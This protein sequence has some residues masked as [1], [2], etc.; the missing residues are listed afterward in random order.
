MLR[1]DPPDLADD[2]G[3]VLAR[4]ARRNE[5]LGRQSVHMRAMIKA[6]P[7][8]P[9]ARRGPRRSAMMEWA[10]IGRES[11]LNQA[12]EDRRLPLKLVDTDPE[13]VG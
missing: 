4:V 11:E 9:R 6:G 8:L 3:V 2:G 10:T 12:H 1:E 5:R 7:S 13:R